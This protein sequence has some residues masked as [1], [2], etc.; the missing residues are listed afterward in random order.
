[1]VS[2]LLL[3]GCS[4]G[5]I[6]GG[7]YEV[8]IHTHAIHT[9]YMSKHPLRLRAELQSGQEVHFDSSQFDITLVD[10]SGKPHKVAT[11]FRDGWT[12]SILG[13]DVLL[14]RLEEDE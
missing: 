12:R 10:D 2:S 4:H 9:G 1:M 13:S 7:F 8:S 5:V 6:L 11:L 3:D 14:K